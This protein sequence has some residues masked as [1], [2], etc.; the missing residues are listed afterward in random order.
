[1]CINSNKCILAQGR[2]RERDE[3]RERE[4]QKEKEKERDHGGGLELLGGKIFF[5]RNFSYHMYT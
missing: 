3:E 4:R 1:M 5:G 2:G